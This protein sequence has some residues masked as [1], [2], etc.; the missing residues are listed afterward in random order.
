MLLSARLLL[1]TQQHK[2]HLQHICIQDVQDHS[3]SRDSGYTIFTKLDPMCVERLGPRLPML[4]SSTCSLPQCCFTSCRGAHAT[5]LRA[6]SQPQIRSIL[7]TG[8]NKSPINKRTQTT[9]PKRRPLPAPAHIVSGW[10][11]RGFSVVG[12]QT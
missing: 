12:T 7:A 1:Q 8:L 6:E 2:R 9:P 10:L 5:N 11:R 3:F 4:S